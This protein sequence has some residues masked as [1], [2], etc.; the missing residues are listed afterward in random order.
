MY[1]VGNVDEE[2]KKLINITETILMKAIDICKPD[3]KFCN[4]GE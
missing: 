3:E 2:G 4:I 1:E